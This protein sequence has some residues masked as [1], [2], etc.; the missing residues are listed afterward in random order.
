MKQLVFSPIDESYKVSYLTNLLGNNENLSI[1]EIKS[2]VGPGDWKPG[3]CAEGQAAGLWDEYVELTLSQMK[4]KAVALGM[5]LRV[6]EDR[7]LEL[8]INTKLANFLTFSISDGEDLLVDATI[9]HVS[10]TI[11]ATVPLGTDPETLIPIFTTTNG[12]TVE[13]SDG[14]PV[15]SG[16]QEFDLTTPVDLTVVSYD[17]SVEKTYEWSVTVATA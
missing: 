1:Y 13:D 4:A 10:K 7:E 8:N 2:A 12:A 16:N 11:A 14:D 3:L 9:N 5:N 6:Y 15:I 17:K